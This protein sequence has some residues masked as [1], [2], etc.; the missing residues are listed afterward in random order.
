MTRRSGFLTIG[1]LIVA[2]F[3]ISPAQAVEKAPTLRQL[4]QAVA[5]HPRDPEA[6]YNLGVKYQNLEKSREAVRAYQQAL[7]L[8]PDYAPALSALGWA[9]VQGGDF[10]AGIKD[11]QKTVELQPGNREARAD[12]GAAYNLEGLDLLKDKYRRSEAIDAFQQAAKVSPEPASAHNNLGVA[13]AAAARPAEA[14]AAFKD[15]IASDP[16]NPEARYNLG[17]ALVAQGKDHEAYAQYFDLKSL[18]PEYAADLSTLIFEPQSKWY[19]TPQEPTRE[20]RPS[21]ALAAGPP[22]SSY[23][24]RR[25]W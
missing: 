6:Y 15:A 9:R 18:N 21:P 3:L 7:Q 20:Y 12:L 1:A 16:N 2:L 5:A 8:K 13:Y 17:A 19:P 14:I 10:K 24:T 25:S 22:K 4:K 11:L 23:S